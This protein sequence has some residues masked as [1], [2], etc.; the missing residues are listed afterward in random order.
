[1]DMMKRH[2]NHREIQ[3]NGCEALLEF[4]LKKM[5]EKSLA[6]K[7]VF[8]AVEKFRT[9][10][11]IQAMG[12]QLLSRL[13]SNGTEKER[14][15]ELLVDGMKANRYNLLVQSSACDTLCTY[16]V[17]YADL[18]VREKKVHELVYYTLR[19]TPRNNDAKKI[20]L[21]ALGKIFECNCRALAKRWFYE[22]DEKVSCIH[23]AEVECK[24]SNI[25]E[26]FLPRKQ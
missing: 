12:Y 11:G 21:A 9:V 23:K 16:I 7:V 15:L 17:P 10:G 2:T 13:S 3:E 24:L 5:Q 19:N 14:M 22:D 26:R 25:R 8:A 1:M 18:L 4:D 6:F 20:Y